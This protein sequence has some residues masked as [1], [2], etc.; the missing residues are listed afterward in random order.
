MPDGYFLVLINAERPV[1]ALRRCALLRSH[2]RSA[3]HT[4]LFLSTLGVTSFQAVPTTPTY[5]VLHQ[6]G[7]GMRTRQISRGASVHCMHRVPDG[8][9]WDFRHGHG[10]PALSLQGAINGAPAMIEVRP[11]QAAIEAASRQ[12]ALAPGAGQMVKR[13]EAKMVKHEETKTEMSTRDPDEVV[14]HGVSLPNWEFRHGSGDQAL[15][16]APA[17]NG[18]P[19]NIVV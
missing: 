12:P 11:T 6:L 19:A 7:C 16:N 9:T 14:N 4:M 10:G 3:V 5:G 8:S 17:I 18:C 2:S 15:A 13:Q 1:E